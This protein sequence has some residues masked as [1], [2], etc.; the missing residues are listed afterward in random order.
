MDGMVGERRPTHLAVV[1]GEQRIHS[2]MAASSERA[3]TERL[4]EY[5]RVNAP[6]RLYASEAA[7]VQA[8]LDAGDDGGAVRCYFDRVGRRW[9]REWLHLDVVDSAAPAEATVTFV[10]EQLAHAG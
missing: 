5:V 7:R 9:G 3:L 6:R 1:H 2:I 8:L 10:P 4:A